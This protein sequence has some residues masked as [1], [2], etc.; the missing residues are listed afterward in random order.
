M[1]LKYNM[2]NTE[3]VTL[4][5]EALEVMESFTYLGRI[6]NGLGGTGADVK[7]SIGKSR[8]AF[9]QL[10]N[11]CHSQQLS[12]N[13]KLRIFNTN[14]KAVQLYGAKTLRTTTTIIKK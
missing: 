7:V 14:V 12:T 1:I 3:P 6:I 13:I 8:A 2:E 11:I 10:K 4:D 5:G 9:L